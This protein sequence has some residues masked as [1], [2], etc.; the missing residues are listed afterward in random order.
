MENEKTL[1]KISAK[2]IRKLH[3][4]NRSVFEINHAQN[5]LGKSYN[6]V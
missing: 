3:D 2:L 5:I 1:G 6:A 4:E